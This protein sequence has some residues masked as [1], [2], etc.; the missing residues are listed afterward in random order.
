MPCSLFTL[1][2][3]EGCKD[4]RHCTYQR[5]RRRPYAR[6]SRS[7][8]TVRR[9]HVRPE[10]HGRPIRPLNHDRQRLSGTLPPSSPFPPPYTYTNQHLCIERPGL[11]R[12]QR[13]KARPSKDAFGRHETSIRHQRLQKDSKSPRHMFVLLRRRRLLTKSPHG[14]DGHPSVFVVYDE[15]R[16]GRG[17]L[18]DCADA[19]LFEYAGGGR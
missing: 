12:R 19:A 5:G 18:F 16:I 1:G 4:G 2:R 3:D 7:P 11:H 9:R 10:R 6:R 8:R 14:R 17:T 13:R 15:R